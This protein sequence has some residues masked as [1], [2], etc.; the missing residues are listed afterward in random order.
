MCCPPDPPDPYAT[1]AA[2]TGQ[3]VSTA[4]T[5]SIV[6]NPNLT[7]DDFTQKT[8][9]IGTEKV[10]D[11]NMLGEGKGGYRDVPRWD[12]TRKLTGDAATIKGNLNQAGI[13]ATDF[14]SQNIGKRQDYD[15]S[16]HMDWFN[17]YYDKTNRGVMDR[18]AESEKSN[19]ANSGIAPGSP[20][21]AEAMRSM[22]EG[23]QVARD[24]AAMD[25]Y[26]QGFAT[27]QY[28]VNNPFNQLSAILNGGQVANVAGS[29]NFQGSNVANTD[30]A[31]LVM[32]DHQN[33]VANSAATGSAIASLGGLFALSD[34]D[35][36]KDIKKVGKADN[37]LDIFTYRYKGEPDSAP[38]SMG[39]M[40]QDA[41]KKHPDAVKTGLDGFLRVNYDKALKKTG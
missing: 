33:K 11:P 3:N 32:Q 8:R 16:K 31:G 9:Q 7:T 1:A 35:A 29:P 2:Q 40:A 17:K 34:E 36:K 15:P 38:K 30:I 27:H 28:N 14:V 6:N 26:G 10:W 20:A 39:I 22:T 5:N 12:T 41:K 13:K 23:N 21:Y 37:G 24:R 18:Q 4:I 19:L 25:S